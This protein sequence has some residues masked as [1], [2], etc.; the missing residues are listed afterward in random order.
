MKLLVKL[1][2]VAGALL[3]VTGCSAD[4]QSMQ[5]SDQMGSQASPPTAMTGQAAGHDDHDHGTGGS[6]GHSM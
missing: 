6:N 1:T 4:T 3:L 5:G 2:L